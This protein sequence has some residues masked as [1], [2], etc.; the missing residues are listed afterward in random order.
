MIFL[1]K[2]KSI[3]FRLFM[4][5][6]IVT[7]L[8]I[9]IMTVA[10]NFLLEPIYKYSKLKTA[11]NICDK[12]DS[13]YSHNKKYDIKEELKE[14]ELKNNIEILIENEEFEIVYNYNKGIVVSIERINSNIHATKTIYKKDNIEVKEIKTSPINNYLILRSLLSN[15]YTLYIKIPVISI[16]ESIKMSNITLMIIGF[17]IVLVSGIVSLIVSKKFTEPI[18]KMNKITR[19]MAKL[20]F[21]EKYS[22]TG[23]DDEINILGKSIN[24]MSEKLESTIE[25][26]R[27]N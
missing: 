18:I 22:I 21:S 14:I 17:V 1:E 10:N 15:G 23:S 25:Q 9:L 27:K 26:L 3:Q 24:E 16:D 2:T 19:K 13:Y 20:D 11:I 7:I 12:V 6:N 5:F 8:V 4:I